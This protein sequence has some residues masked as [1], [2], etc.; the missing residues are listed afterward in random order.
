VGKA[1][2]IIATT[3]LNVNVEEIVEKVIETRDK[4]Y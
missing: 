3:E 1:G 2:L 4:N